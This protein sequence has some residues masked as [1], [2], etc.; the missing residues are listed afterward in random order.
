MQNSLNNRIK[1]GTKRMKRL[2]R[3]FACKLAIP[4]KYCKFLYY[5]SQKSKVSTKDHVVILNTSLETDNIGD[6]IIMY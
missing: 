2:I 1:F 6:N 5:S 3:M 4:V